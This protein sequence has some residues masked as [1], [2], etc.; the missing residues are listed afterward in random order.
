[1]RCGEL[2]VVSES[3]ADASFREG[4]S[5]AGVN[6]LG[7]LPAQLRR[8]VLL[9]KDKVASGTTLEDTEMLAGMRGYNELCKRR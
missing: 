9:I 6:T 2:S 5:I 3:A 7:E 1:M 8:N 4:R